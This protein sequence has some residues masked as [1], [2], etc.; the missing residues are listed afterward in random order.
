MPR[1]DFYSCKDDTYPMGSQSNR[2]RWIRHLPSVCS[3]P[4]PMLGISFN[5]YYGLDNVEV[6]TPI[7]HIW[8]LRLESLK[9]YV[10]IMLSTRDGIQKQI[11]FTAVNSS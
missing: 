1:K 6:G 5:D 3:A 9:N 4:G 8:I 2:D 10:T 7:S 11:F